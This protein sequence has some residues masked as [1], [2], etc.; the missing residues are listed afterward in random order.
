MENMNNISTDLFYKIRSRFAG[1]KLGKETGETTINPEEAVFFDFDY[2]DEEVPIGHISI[3]LAEEGSMKVYYS[4]N[5]TE[6]MSGLE[7]DKWFDFLKELRLFAKSRLMSFDTRDIAKDNLDKRDFQFLSQNST[8]GESIMKE[9][10]YG[11]SK[12]SYQKLN[13]TKL[14]IKHKKNVDE[15]VPGSRTR[16]ISALFVENQDGERFKY[17]FIHLSGARAMQRHV[18]NGGV[19]YDDIGKSII[20]MSEEIAQLKSFSNYVN[21]NDLLNSDTNSIIDRGTERLNSL[22]EQLAKLAKQTHYEN[23]KETFQAAVIEEIPEDVIEN[24]KEQFTVKNFNEEIKSV[25]PILY[26]LM[27]EGSTINYSDIVAMTTQEQEE[28]TE[29][30]TEVKSEFDRF[31]SWVLNLGEESA[32]TSDDQEEQNQAIK[33]LQELVG[34][35]FPAGVDGTN[36]IESLKGIIDDPKLY[37]EI[38]AQSKEDPDSCVRP[39]VKAWLEQNAPEVIDQLDFGDM[40]EEPKAT[41]SFESPEQEEAVRARLKELE[42]EDPDNMY[43]I[44]ADEF[45]MD[46]GELRDALYKSANEDIAEE[47]RPSTIK[48]LAEF[49]YSFYDKETGSFPKGPEGV[50]IMVGKKFGEQAEMLARKMVERMAPQQDTKQN[51]EL[52]ELVRI[53]ELVKF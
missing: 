9:S 5:I 36:A 15:Q 10:M 47:Q 28:V 22:K 19:P 48:E 23:Y 1:L 8:V 42:D 20:Q 18:A 13:D 44:V 33:K 26:R 51:P 25:F 53:K 34:Q 24:F 49:I 3:S 31:E 38:K 6:T 40:V 14:I 35:H 45:E 43:A 41:E 30:Q 21:K 4:T 29:E 46:E 52:A 50:S 7:K 39:L 37:Q 17:P 12:T 11:S 27:K 32:I 16:N 2:I